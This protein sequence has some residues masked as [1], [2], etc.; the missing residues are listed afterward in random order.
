[1]TVASLF[2]LIFT[3]QLFAQWKQHKTFPYCQVGF[4]SRRIAEQITHSSHIST[5]SDDDTDFDLEKSSIHHF[6]N[7][8]PTF[9]PLCLHIPASTR[10]WPSDVSLTE[11]PSK[12]VMHYL[13][14]RTQM[15]PGPYNKSWDLGLACL[16]G[17]QSSVPGLPFNRLVPG[18]FYTTQ[19]GRA[20]S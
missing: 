2:T 16:L 6:T 4:R 20:P 8:S 1:M 5:C 12:K 7:I 9:V 15:S 19:L 11:S 17:P 14:C 3:P 13:D 10:F 18:S